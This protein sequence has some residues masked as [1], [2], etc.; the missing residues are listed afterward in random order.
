MQYAYCVVPA[1][2]MECSG[3]GR[4]RAETSIAYVR[5]VLALVDVNNGSW[6]KC[7]K[8]QPISCT[9]DTIKHYLRTGIAKIRAQEEKVCMTRTPETFLDKKAHIYGPMGP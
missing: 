4:V 6:S 8:S 7:D 9:D 5:R 3:T 2:S 1:N